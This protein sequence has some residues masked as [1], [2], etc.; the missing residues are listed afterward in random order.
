[1][2][3]ISKQQNKVGILAEIRFFID[4]IWASR[5]AHLTRTFG[6]RVRSRRAIRSIMCFVSLR[7][8]FRYYPSR[9]ARAKPVRVS[10]LRASGIRYF[11]IKYL[12]MRIM[13]SILCVQRRDVVCNVSTSG[14]SKW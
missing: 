10:A 12:I 9:N 3:F 13:R 2:Y 14:A 11:G 1:M 4:I 6:A 8:W 5:F 7:T